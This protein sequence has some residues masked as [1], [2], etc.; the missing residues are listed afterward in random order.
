MIENWLEFWLWANNLNFCQRFVSS[1]FNIPGD[2]EAIEENPNYA[3]S[4][5]RYYTLKKC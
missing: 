4:T 2:W 3:E 1:K 5:S